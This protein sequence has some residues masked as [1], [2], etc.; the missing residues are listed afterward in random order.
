MS[1]AITFAA[2]S[3]RASLTCNRPIS[4]T[5]SMSTVSP[6]V[7]A[8]SRSPRTTVPSGSMK[9]PSSYDMLSGSL[10]VPLGTLRPEIF[11]Y[12]AKPPGSK[13]FSPWKVSHAV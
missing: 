12:S 9:D 2:P 3:A 5:P 1:V 8:I 7:T 10:A 4:P 13:L 11:R 6:G